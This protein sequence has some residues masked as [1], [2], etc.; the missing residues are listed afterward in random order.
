MSPPP[1][2]SPKAPPRVISYTRFGSRKQ[3]KGLSYVRQIESA[4][5][6]CAANGYTLD[7]SDQF[8]DLGVSA[9]SGANSSTGDLA[10]LQSAFRRYDWRG[11]SR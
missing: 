3:A 10:E 2:S 5:E 1:D 4:R 9:Y 7:D 11:T 8:K 6:W